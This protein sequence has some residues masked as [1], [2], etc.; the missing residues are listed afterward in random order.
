[1]QDA[2]SQ[3]LAKAIAKNGVV[4]KLAPEEL[5]YFDDLI[6]ESKGKK[7]H[8]LGFGVAETAVLLSPLAWAAV[9]K[10]F[11]LI[12]EDFLKTVGKD[13]GTVTI[14]KIKE[15]WATKDETSV[16]ATVEE[17]Q[18]AVYKKVTAEGLDAERARAVAAAVVESL[19]PKT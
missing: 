13:L 18:E 11:Q 2:E 14:A 8:E 6:V 12:A 10:V 17:M 15:Y 19:S 9:G 5:D 1:M 16:T 3:A 4:A 7:D